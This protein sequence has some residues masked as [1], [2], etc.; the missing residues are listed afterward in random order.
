MDEIFHHPWMIGFESAFGVKI[1][2]YIYKKKRRKTKHSKNQLP[3]KSGKS[4]AQQ[5][6]HAESGTTP[7]KHG[8][9]KNVS[10]GTGGEPQKKKEYELGRP[11]KKKKKPYRQDIYKKGSIDRKE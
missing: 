7:M 1:D 6:K 5:Y 8:Q 4:R 11:E 2:E 10:A 9:E 3:H